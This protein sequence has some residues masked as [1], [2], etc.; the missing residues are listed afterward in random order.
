MERK[1]RGLPALLLCVFRFV[2]LLMSG[3]QA[4]ALEN[5]LPVQSVALGG[6]AKLPRE[7]RRSV[8]SLI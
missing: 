2:R 1:N 3:H 8:F 6:G 4:V 5:A 7:Q